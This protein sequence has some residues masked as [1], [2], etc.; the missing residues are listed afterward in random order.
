M[1]SSTSSLP[2]SP[3]VSLVFML[4]VFLN[5]RSSE[6]HILF[7]LFQFRCLCPG[8][9]YL[10]AHQKEGHQLPHWFSNHFPNSSSS[11]AI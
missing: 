3:R 7:I 5:S 11:G 1:S 8:R 6:S 4:L 2:R 10:S 9:S